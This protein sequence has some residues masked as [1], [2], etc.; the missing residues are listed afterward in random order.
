MEDWNF[1]FKLISLVLGATGLWKLAEVV[2]KALVDK[3]HR[4]AATKKLHIETESQILDNWIQWSR[5]QDQKIKELELKLD[6]VRKENS[7]LMV[8][9]KILQD[10]MNKLL[11]ENS[12]LR[13]KNKK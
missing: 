11:E 9:L 12:L 8:Q 13:K 5:H 4:K 1:Y 10:K 2:I 3:T 6:A 7:A